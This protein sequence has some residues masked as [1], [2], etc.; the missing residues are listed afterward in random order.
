MNVFGVPEDP[1]KRAT[2][3]EALIRYILPKEA[4]FMKDTAE[5]LRNHVLVFSLET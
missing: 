2:Q 4:E 3:A 5:G 1:E